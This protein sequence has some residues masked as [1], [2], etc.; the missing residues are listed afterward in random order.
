MTYLVLAKSIFPKGVKVGGDGKKWIQSLKEGGDQR[1]HSIPRDQC[2][3]NEHLRGCSK[4]NRMSPRAFQFCCLV[5]T[6]DTALLC[7]VVQVVGC[8]NASERGEKA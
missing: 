7:R 2:E 8:T 5:P 1:G 6:L 4:S 3:E